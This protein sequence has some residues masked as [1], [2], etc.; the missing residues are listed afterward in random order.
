MDLFEAP[1]TER[2]ID[3]GENR[4]ISHLTV[5]QGGLLWVNQTEIGF[6]IEKFN[7]SDKSVNPLHATTDS[8]DGNSP[9]TI[10]MN[11]YPLTLYRAS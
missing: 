3:V 11:T 2:T 6:R 10:T 9:S 7:S 5:F 1:R 8:V 4:K